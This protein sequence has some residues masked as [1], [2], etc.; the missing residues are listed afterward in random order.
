MEVFNNF[1]GG[2][3]TVAAQGSLADSELIDISNMDLDSR[4]S[5]KRRTGVRSTSKRNPTMWSDIQGMK[6]NNIR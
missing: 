2:L 4:G 1:I 3:N 6:W 5:L